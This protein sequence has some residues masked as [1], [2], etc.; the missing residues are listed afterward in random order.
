MVGDGAGGGVAED[1]LQVA[2]HGVVAVERLGQ[3][4][5]PPGVGWSGW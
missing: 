2:D 1:A 5:G 3:E 4:S